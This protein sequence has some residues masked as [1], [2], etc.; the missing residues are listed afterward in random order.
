MF[1]V[2][3][4]DAIIKILIIKIGS[5]INSKPN[6]FNTMSECQIKF[7]KNKIIKFIKFIMKG[8]K[9]KYILW[10]TYF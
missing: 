9:F 3:T 5:A 8:N 10:K 2:Y 6:N 4:K 1:Q 7:I